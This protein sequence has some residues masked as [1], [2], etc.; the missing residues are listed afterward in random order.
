MN[1]RAAAT[2][3]IDFVTFVESTLIDPIT[4]KPFVLTDA[5]KT[6]ASHGYR[7]TPDGKLKY[8]TQTFGAPMKSGK[9]GFAAMNVLYTVR[10]LG[11]SLAEGICVA[12]DFE[13]A[14]GRVFKAVRDIVEAS[15]MLAADADIISDKITFRSTGSTI[16][17][18]ASD[19]ASAAGANPNVIAFDEPWGIVSE[20]GRRLWDELPPSPARK[21]SYRLS[22]SYAGFE[23]ES[24]LL[25]DLY[26][27]GKAQP[28][29][30]PDLY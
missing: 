21:I 13:Q 11:G 4:R 20:R 25:E 1:K 23:D 26:K 17:A 24:A 29:I 18:I 9:T 16:I 19:A 2:P 14:Q 15:P 7:L 30:G 27:R 28:K 5:E 22:V 8:P 10:V 12:N 6:F 3:S